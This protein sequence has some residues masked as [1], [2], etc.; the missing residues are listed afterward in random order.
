MFSSNFDLVLR[1]DGQGVRVAGTS[2]AI[3]NASLVM[4]RVTLQQNGTSPRERRISAAPRWGAAPALPAT[5]FTAGEALA[6]GVETYFVESP[7]PGYAS[8]T[9]SQIVT[10]EDG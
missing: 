7:T 10:L 5:G 6:L 1:I 3:P 2:S 4:R 8:F 9:W